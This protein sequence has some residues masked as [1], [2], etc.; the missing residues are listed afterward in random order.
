MDLATVMGLLIG[1]GLI[2]WSLSADLMQF[3]DPASV[4]IVIG[5]MVG[6]TLTSIPIG[7]F[8]KVMRVAK[9]ALFAKQLQPGQ[10]ISTLVRFGEI[11]RRD[12]ILALETMIG[13][14]EDH[15]LVRG[16]QMAVDGN[17]P[18]TIQQALSTE[19]DCLAQ[20]HSE[21]REL[22]E[23]FAK[24]APA[25]GML[26]TIIGLIL[27]LAN[28]NDVSTIAPN[29]AVA[30]VTTF[31]GALIANLVCLPLADKLAARD[32]EEMRIKEMIIQGVMAIQ[33]GDNPKVVEQ[34]L[35]IFLPPDRRER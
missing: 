18:E 32:R 34:K 9:Q 17:D 8:K 26:G 30:L 31:Y 21:G 3:F 35:T 5:G 23:L 27:M 13:E 15:F 12:G 1:G 20:R 11:A 24:Y 7:N 19:L 14:V 16:I 28:L 4:A 29:M 25:Y 33:S 22:F 6:S 2:L 10:L